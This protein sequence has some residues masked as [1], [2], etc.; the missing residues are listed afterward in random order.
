VFFVLDVFGY[1]KKEMHLV[2]N[3]A[4]VK[5]FLLAQDPGAFQRFRAQQLM[6]S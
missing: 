3:I 4:V 5:K 6:S 1:L 2:C